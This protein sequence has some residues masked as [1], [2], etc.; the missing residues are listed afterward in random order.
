VAGERA[1][2]VAHAAGHRSAAEGDE[3]DVE[4]RI[5]SDELEADRGGALAGG[6]VQAVLDQVGAGHLG[7]L[8]RQQAGVFDVLAFEPDVGPARFRASI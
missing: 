3:H 4:S 7:D 5:V 8:A 1:H 2:G 6:Q